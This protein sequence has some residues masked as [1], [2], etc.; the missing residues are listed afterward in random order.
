MEFRKKGEEIKKEV[1][2]LV[3]KHGLK[4]NNLILISGKTGIKG[5][6]HSKE[7]E[8]IRKCSNS[9]Y[10]YVQEGKEFI[11]R[12]VIKNYKDKKGN[13]PI[14]MFTVNER[15]VLEKMIPFLIDKLYELGGLHEKVAKYEC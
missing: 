8:K 9:T 12:L 3:K 1:K 13:Q 5:E 2:T 14:M 11:F 4:I 15:D 7:V 10:S 6:I